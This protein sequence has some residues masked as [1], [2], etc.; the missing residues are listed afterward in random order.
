MPHRKSCKILATLGPA[1]DAPSRIRSLAMTGV[2]SFRLNFSHGSHDEHRKRFENI[3]EAE[4]ATGKS[5]PILADMQ[6][7]KIR[8][9]VLNGD[10]Q[11]LRYG[12]QLK[13]VCDDHSTEDAV[14]P[15]P[16]PEL[17]DA[18]KPGDMM[19]L[20]DGLIRL[21]LTQNSGQSA[22]AKVEVPGKLTNK[23][24]INIP[25]RRLPIAA[26]T[27]KDR[28]DLA[29][30]LENKADYIA[31]S[32]VQTAKDVREAREIIGNRAGIVSKIEKPSAMDEIEEI[33]AASDAVMVARGDLGVELPLEQVPIAQRRIIRLARRAGKPVIV[34]T[35]MLQSMVDSPTPTRA[36]A[37]DTASA[38]YLGADAV[39]LSAESAVGRHPE[40]TVAIMSRIIEAV[41]QDEFYWEEIY[42]GLGRA[43]ANSPGAVSVSAR[44]TVDLLGCK[45]VLASTKTGGTAFAISRERPRAPI[46]GVTPDPAAARRISLAWGVEAVVAPDYANFEELT[47]H[48]RDIARQKA[49][50]SGG[51]TILLTAGIPMGVKGGTN[52]MKVITID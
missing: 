25:G 4:K 34:A 46:L 16:H 26:L 6:G 13:L 33:I 50:V 35:Q 19:M 37:S 45:A 7:P 5:L 15:I 42:N 38:V 47:A 41:E 51:D 3:R 2:D 27:D 39:M 44:H 18:L 20:D 43:E 11:V 17:F 31:L 28:T 10:E 29:F 48:A 23:K 1:S 9:G 30:A 32:F 36:E 40:A 14:L 52:L 21:T 24:G 12:D 49:G 22:R 8:V